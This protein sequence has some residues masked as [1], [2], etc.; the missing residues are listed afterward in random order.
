M[1]DAR[2]NPMRT[3]LTLD[4]D[5]LSAA[6][7]LAAQRNET[8]GDVISGLVRQAL[9][10]SVQQAAT[11]NGVPLL[12]RRSDGGPVTLEIVNALRD[13]LP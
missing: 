11:R 2:G 1:L 13:E 8:I 4:D 6:K 10:P 5:V 3:T 12:P 7:A 9:T